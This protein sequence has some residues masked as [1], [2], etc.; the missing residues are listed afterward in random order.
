MR[1]AQVETE[2]DIVEQR[3]LKDFHSFILVPLYLTM[4]TTSI[5]N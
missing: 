3:V 5:Y 1:H 4:K 2:G